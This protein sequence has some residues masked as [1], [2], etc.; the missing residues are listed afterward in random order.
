MFHKINT[1]TQSV[2]MLFIWCCVLFRHHSQW[3]FTIYLCIY[4]WASATFSPLY[5]DDHRLK[6]AYKLSKFMVV[7]HKL[8]FCFNIQ[9][10]SLEMGK[11]TICIVWFYCNLHCVCVLVY[12]V[13]DLCNTLER[14]RNQNQR[15]ALVFIQA[16]W[17][18]GKV[19]RVTFHVI[20]PIQ[21]NLRYTCRLTLLF[22]FS[23][24]IQSD[25]SPKIGTASECTQIIYL[26]M[27]RK[28]MNELYGV[29]ILIWFIAPIKFSQIFQT[30]FVNSD[31]SKFSWIFRFNMILTKSGF[32]FNWMNA[33]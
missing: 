15:Y 32:Y 26:N 20:P 5:F 13:E 19:K 33:D 10:V 24:F 21:R 9:I 17:A 30:V 31:L 23:S 7:L 3:I 28:W 1:H 25:H 4:L 14:K 27:Y 16:M 6:S 2:W 11:C 12:L 29:M 8:L 18:P 22:L